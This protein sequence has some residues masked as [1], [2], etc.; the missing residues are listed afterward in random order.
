MR[1]W[2][3][4]LFR[5]WTSGQSQTKKNTFGCSSIAWSR[6][7]GGLARHRRFCPIRTFGGVDQLRHGCGCGRFDEPVSVP[8]GPGKTST[9]PPLPS[10]GFSIQ[11]TILR[12]KL[13]CAS[14]RHDPTSGTIRSY[15]FARMP[16]DGSRR[17][18]GGL[19]RD[20]H[21]SPRR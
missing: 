8:N 2:A 7:G 1:R 16:S 6:T 9:C 18:F 10:G 17:G 14:D 19:V 21:D 11:R 5:L 15:Y 13:L 20:P 3:T 4:K 12:F